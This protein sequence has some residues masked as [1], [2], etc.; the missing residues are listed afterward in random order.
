MFIRLTND[1]LTV[2]FSGSEKIWGVHGNFRIPRNHVAS[3]WKG[4][5]KTTWRELRIPGSFLPGGI[6]AGTEI[7]PR[8]K[9]YWYVSR[10]KRHPVTIELK[11]HTY[12]RL[13]LGVEDPASIQ[14]LGLPLE[15][16]PK[17]IGDTMTEGA[18]GWKV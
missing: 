4:M 10:A 8:G 6:K 16:P 13:V 12:K 11:G 3:A 15:N 17:D 14:S 1:E 5:P 18:T 2:E 9:E 7:T